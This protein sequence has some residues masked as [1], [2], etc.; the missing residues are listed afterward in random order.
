MEAGEYNLL[1]A[2]AA[3]CPFF[4]FPVRRKGG[5]FV[6]LAQWQDNVCLFTFLEEYKKNPHSAEPWAAMTMYNEL[7]N[8]HGVALSRFDYNPLH[9][10]K[11][12]AKH[13]MELLRIFYVQGN[14]YEVGG[15]EEL[16]VHWR[17][18]GC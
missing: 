9:I 14:Q 3:T 17:L 13:L 5:H 15:V 12:E 1:R 18:V 8:T 10:S 7:V 2:R 4:I 16:L 6:M 11:V